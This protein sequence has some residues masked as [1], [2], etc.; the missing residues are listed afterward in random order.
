MTRYEMI[1]ALD[2]AHTSAMTPEDAAAHLNTTTTQRYVEI[3]AKEVIRVLIDAEQLI[4][5]QAAA[6][7]EANPL[8]AVALQG[9]SLFR[10]AREY[11]VPLRM[12]PGQK[13]YGY[14]EAMKTAGLVSQASFDTIAAM[15]VENV[16]IAENDGVYP[17]VPGDIEHARELP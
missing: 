16:S 8:H 4:P 17:V 15:S 6:A 7:D 1:Q 11:S 5:I 3:D 10:A 12:W 14:L 9:A 2:V 13:D